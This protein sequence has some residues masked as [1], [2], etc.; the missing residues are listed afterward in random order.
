LRR[1][2]ESGITNQLQMM[3]LILKN[4]KNLEITNRSRIDVLCLEDWENL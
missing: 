1:L 2:R 3:I 4:W